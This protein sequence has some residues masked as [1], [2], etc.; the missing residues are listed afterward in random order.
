VLG[1]LLAEQRAHYAQAP[2]AAAKLL[3]VGERP[4]QAGLDPIEVAATT[5]LVTALFNHD[6]FVMRR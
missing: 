5:I 6:G 1:R 4:R 2:E 3:A